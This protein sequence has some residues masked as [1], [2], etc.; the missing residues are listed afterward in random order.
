[1]ATSFTF[2]DGERRKVFFN[3]SA[4]DGVDDSFVIYDATYL[5]ENSEGQTVASG[6]CTI[7]EHD[8]VCTIQPPELGSYLLT[9]S[10]VVGDEI[11]KGTATI[12]VKKKR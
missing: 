2:I 9:C 3:I 8:V 12:N 4:S 10:C 6:N 5:L 11:I 1:M 7:D